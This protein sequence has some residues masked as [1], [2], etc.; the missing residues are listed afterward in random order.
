[1]FRVIRAASGSSAAEFSGADALIH[2]AEA[3]LSGWTFK[4]STTMTCRYCNR[5]LDSIR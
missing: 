3:D 2:C 5:P 4:G 1:M